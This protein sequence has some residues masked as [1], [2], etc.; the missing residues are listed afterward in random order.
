MDCKFF[1]VLVVFFG[2][3]A[4]QLV[5]SENQHPRHTFSYDI[6]SGNLGDAV[7]ARTLLR[8][9][10][11]GDHPWYKQAPQKVITL[12]ATEENQKRNSNTNDSIPDTNSA[13]DIFAMLSHNKEEHIATQKATS[14]K[15]KGSSFTSQSTN[16]KGKGKDSKRSKTSKS[17]KRSSSDDAG[18][19]PL[20]T[21][22]IPDVALSYAWPID[23]TRTTTT[24]MPSDTDIALLVAETTDWFELAVRSF[25]TSL[26]VLISVDSKLDY[27]AFGTDVPEP[28][29]DLLIVLKVVEYTFYVTN[30]SVDDAP[31]ASRIND[32]MRESITP[33]YIF[34][35]VRQIPAF[36]EVTE[37]FYQS[38][39]NTFE[40]V[41][42]P[43]RSP[44]NRPSVNE[45]SP[46]KTPAPYI[47]SSS[48]PP[49]NLPSFSF[50]PSSSEQPS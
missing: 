1:Q 26:V 5:A 7:T 42:T 17:K 49:S 33:E 45:P 19:S 22:S 50:K 34:T 15:S 27:A 32:I 43:V 11:L 29:F 36:A 10:K 38:L 44:T 40:P 24:T 46:S 35:V 25:D 48:V 37:V 12:S 14:K 8:S 21:R 9:S 6:E 16:G 30:D 3:L 39:D 31:S 2:F 18:P 20:Q 47:D 41:P 28:R 13:S 4:V 23:R